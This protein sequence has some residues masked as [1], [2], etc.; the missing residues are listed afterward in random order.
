MI[1]ISGIKL[2]PEDG[3]I[4][5]AVALELKINESG[6]KNIIIRRRSLDARKKDDI[7]YIYSVDAELKA[8]DGAVKNTGRRKNGVTVSVSD[9]RDYALPNGEITPG[10]RPVIAGFGPAGM[11]AALS[12]ARKG[13]CPI[14]LERGKDVDRRRADVEEFWNGGKFDPESN[15]Q[16]G[17]GGAGTFSDGKLTSKN[18]PADTFLRNLSRPGLPRK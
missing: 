3:N 15:V 14:V 6:I 7:H 8:G 10:K 9:H 18:V 11:F 13:L 4:K 2:R 17:E 1:R 5:R 16:F 12:L